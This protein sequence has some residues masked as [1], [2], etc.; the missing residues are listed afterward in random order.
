MI[1][2]VQINSR[3]HDIN[4]NNTNLLLY[5][6]TWGQFASSKEY[7]DVMPTKACVVF[8]F[9][10]SFNVTNKS[11]NETQSQILEE[12]QFYDDIVQVEM[13]K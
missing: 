4:E 10:N 1:R 3:F 5:R 9:G 6:N 11:E 8:L 13:V 7:S 2:N 12:H